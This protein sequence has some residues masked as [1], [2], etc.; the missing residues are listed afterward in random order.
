MSE[1]SRFVDIVQVDGS[2]GSEE[3]EV[4]DSPRRILAAVPNKHS[5]AVSWSARQRS[6][7]ASLSP[8]SNRQVCCNMLPTPTL[9]IVLNT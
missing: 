4:Q 8:Q 7:C 2:A 1:S 9:R 3:E 6:R 5:P